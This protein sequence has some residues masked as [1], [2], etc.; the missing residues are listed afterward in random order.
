MPDTSKRVLTT[1]MSGHQA[2][3]LAL[4]MMLCHS[5]MLTS[6]VEEVLEVASAAEEVLEV[7]CPPSEFTPE[8]ISLIINKRSKRYSSFHE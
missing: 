2:G 7:V 4:L 8:Q 5:V 3:L 6:A 1:A